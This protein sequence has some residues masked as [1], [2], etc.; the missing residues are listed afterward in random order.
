MAELVHLVEGEVVMTSLNEEC[1]RM[2]N[3]VWVEADGRTLTSQ[4]FGDFP[5]DGGMLSCVRGSQRSAEDAYNDF[6]Q[7]LKQKAVGVWAVT[8]GEVQCVKLEDSGLVRSR[9]VNNSAVADGDGTQMRHHCYIDQRHLS[10]GQKKKLRAKLLE[11][12]VERGKL[13]PFD[14][15]ATGAEDVFASS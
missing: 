13:H 2:C 8:V 11:H 14:L 7:R 5:K 15:S 4:L 3:A 6:T 9:V 1:Y 12:A 10:R